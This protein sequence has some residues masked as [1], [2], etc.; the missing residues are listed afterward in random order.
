MWT[1]DSYVNYVNTQNDLK[2]YDESHQAVSEKA[3]EDEAQYD[4]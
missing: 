2:I 3:L 4:H 1:Y